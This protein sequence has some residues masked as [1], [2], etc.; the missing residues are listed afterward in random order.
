M[1]YIISIGLLW[2]SL[3]GCFNDPMP[4]RREFPEIELPKHE[5]IRLNTAC[6]FD[7]EVPIYAIV[8]PDSSPGSEPCWLNISYPKFNAVLHLSYKPIQGEIANF[9]KLLDETRMLVYKHIQK[10]DGIEEIPIQ[11]LEDSSIQGIKFELLGNTATSFQFF[12]T[13]RKSHYL[14]GALYF[15]EKT[16]PDS[17]APV[18]QH[19]YKDAERLIQTCRWKA[20]D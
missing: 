11:S 17:I 20:N 6:P 4:R 15:N 1:K 5:Y 3:T 2:V 18:F 16:N 14:R 10:A 9:E 13:D 12:L 7:F 8:L 19:L